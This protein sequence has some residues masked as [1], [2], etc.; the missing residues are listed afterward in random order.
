MMNKKDIIKKISSYIILFLIMVVVFSIAMIGTY[1][2][3]NERIRAHIAESKELLINQNG[4]PLFTDYIKG[5]NLDVFTDLLIMNTAMNKGK[6]EDE[7]V[8]IRAFENSRYNNEEDNSY[9]SLQETVENPDIHNNQEYSRYWH[10]IQTII[11]PLLL[12]FNYEEI[13]YIFM[14]LI[15]VLLGISL[16]LIN[17]N[18]SFMHS[19]AFLVSMLA[20]C[21]FIVP[22]SI[23]YSAIFIITLLAVIIVNL[24]H[25]KQK[26]KFIPYLFFIIGGL[27][28]FFDLLTAP[29]LT[30]GIPLIIEVLLRS[31]EESLSIKKAFLEIIK[32]SI[33]WAIAYGTIFFAKWVIAS[34]I[35]QKDLITVAINQILFRTNGSEEYPATKIGAIVENFTYLYNNVL[36]ACGIVTIIGWIIALIKT[37]KNKINWKKILILLIVS[38]YPYVWYMVFAGHSTIHAFFTYRIQ[39]IAIFGVLC[40]MLEFVDLKTKEKINKAGKEKQE[41]NE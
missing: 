2:L 21:I 11:R 38:I 9:T 23:Q 20:V 1:L 14:L 13:R 27:T 28:T 5:A 37:R 35:M 30:L 3:P 41:G 29:L 10:G 17:K 12:F 33:L 22:M 8:F 16:L 15:F 34:L 18:I 4:N 19:M 36:L 32:L 26:A 6:T 40:I 31:R 39:A 25:K 7:S 24:L